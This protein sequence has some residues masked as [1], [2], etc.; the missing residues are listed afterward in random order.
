[1]MK[2]TR[3]SVAAIG[4]VAASVLAASA[5]TSGATTT[6]NGTSYSAAGSAGTVSPI[7]PA[8]KVCPL[9]LLGLL[10]S[11]TTGPL[12]AVNGLLGS[13]LTPVTNIVSDIQTIPSS[14]VS[15][16]VGSGLSASQPAAQL[17]R[18]SPQN[19]PTTGAPNLPTCG[20][21]GWDA[22]GA[23]DCYTGLP[24]TIPASALLGLNV[25]GVGGYA[26]DDT[27]GYIGAAQAAGVKLS[28]LGSSLGTIG[29]VWSQA[30]CSNNPSTPNCTAAYGAVNANILPSS[31][32]PNGALNLKIANNGTDPQVLSIN[33]AA[34]S[35]SNKTV[36]V[37][38]VGVV[39]VAVTNHL[40]TL[41]LALST[42]QLTSLL[43]SL[44]GLSSLVSDTGT[45]TIGIG[46]GSSSTASGATASGLTI[47]ADLSL[48]IKLSVL[49]L[50][51]V[52]IT[53]GAGISSPDLLN[54]SLAYSK[55]TAG[56][57]AA[58]WIPAGLI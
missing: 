20:Q 10:G 15:A 58:S 42:S 2:A 40:L 13:L 30:Q 33:G 51:S 34:L 9:S 37:A 27:T 45:V 49:G 25:T 7:T 18:P 5:A 46:P 36:S 55:A 39:T 35:S 21:Q 24:V 53:T 31:T 19:D 29:T 50:A 54:V 56:A 43:P 38:G 14:V 28:L 26:T 52:E 4:V 8:V 3:L 17:T 57:A 48:D 16:L 12:G 32:Y 23:G 47:S 44:A 22:S 6:A 41:T 1:M 11:C